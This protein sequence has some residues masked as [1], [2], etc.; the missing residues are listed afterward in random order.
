MRIP[1]RTLLYAVL[2]AA[3]LALGGFILAPP[4]NARPG[5]FQPLGHPALG[6]MRQLVKTYGRGS[7][8]G[9]DATPILLNPTGSTGTGQGINLETRF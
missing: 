4:A 6:I 5:Q 1:I 9:W 2:P 3:F 7:E 8:F